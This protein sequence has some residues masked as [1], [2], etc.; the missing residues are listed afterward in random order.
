MTKRIRPVPDELLEALAH[1]PVCLA[2]YDAEHRLIFLTNPPVLHAKL[3]EDSLPIGTSL[4]D[5]VTLYAYHGVF[6]PGDPEARVATVM[7][8]DR[9]KAS[10][11][12]VRTTLG[13]ALEFCNEPL[14]TGG[15]TSIVSDVTAFVRAESEAMAM[16]RA[17][18]GVLDQLREGV[19]VYGPDRRLTLLNPAYANLIGAPPGGIHAGMSLPEVF[20]LLAARGEYGNLDDP[21]FVLRRIGTDRGLPQQQMRERPNGEVIR[22]TSKPTSDGGFIIEVDDLTELK[23]AE[24]DA[25]QRATLLDAVLAALPYG[26]AVY[27]SDRRVTML[28]EACKRLLADAGPTLGEHLDTLIARR[29]AAGEYGDMPIEEVRRR[30]YAWMTE[31]QSE[32]MRTRADGTTLVGRFTR[33]PDGGHVAVISD[34]TALHEAQ[35]QAREQALRQQVMLENSRSG[36]SLFDREG[37]L[38]AANALA[39]RLTGLD[40]DEMWA[41]RTIEDIRRAQAERGEF[42]SPEAAAAFTATRP[43]IF[44]P[45]RYVRTRPDG[46]VVEITTEPTPDGGFVRTL[47][48]VTEDRRVRAELQRAKDAAEDASRAKSRFLTTMTHEL[49]TPLNAVIGFSDAL[50]ARNAG[51]G[52]AVGAAESEEFIRAIN[53][54]GRH[55]LSLI[56]DILDIARA[57]AVV[58]S[59]GAARLD[60]YSALQAVA[61]VARSQAA[62]AGLTLALD[63]PPGL[64]RILADE[65][66]LRQVLQGLLTNAV[67]FT[68]SGGTVTLAAAMAGP[69]LAITISDTGIGIAPEDLARAFE[70]FVQLETTLARRFGGSGLGLHLARTLSRA[71]GFDLRLQSQPGQ[72]TLAILTIPAASLAAEEDGASP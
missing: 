59:A 39:S 35:R 4:R 51:G 27:G 69:D 64:P 24:D 34:I 33:L 26:V 58:L 21:D 22:V 38:I 42:G 16:A 25:R 63:L 31:G 12:V 65:K 29:H 14:P 8:M 1:L 6:G 13:R 66:R 9:S 7:R 57:E 71:M 2:I 72:G 60:V 40:T 56:D 17:S 5:I 61:R 49:R 47:T 62:E 46:S 41:G 23:R 15:F 55:L 3:A 67:K 54:A 19:G 30:R 36:I 53:D 45:G 37:R 70:P 43:H 28:N 32:W 11:R 18:Q 20:A 68:E 10:R 52:P 50:L 44:G 48:D